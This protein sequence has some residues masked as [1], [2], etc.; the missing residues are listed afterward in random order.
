MDKV[1]VKVLKLV[2]VTKV[3]KLEAGGGVRTGFEGGAMPLYMRLPKEVSLMHLLKLSMLIVNL[4]SIEAKFEVVK[5]QE[6]LLLKKVPKR[7]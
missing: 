4:S 3:K 7:Y 5:L 6:K 1:L 2:K